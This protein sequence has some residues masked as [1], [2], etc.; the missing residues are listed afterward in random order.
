MVGDV[1]RRFE[2]AAVLQVGGDAG[3][4]EGMVADP[5]LDAAYA[6]C[7]ILPCFQDKTTSSHLYAP[8]VN[9]SFG[10]TQTSRLP[11]QTACRPARAPSA[12]RRQHER[13]GTTNTNL[14]PVIHFH[15]ISDSNL[16]FDPSTMIRS[17]LSRD[18]RT[19]GPVRLTTMV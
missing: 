11:A 6:A 16:P 13:C 17:S 12:F 15:D 4:A 14:A 8:G 2:R 10:M 1:L 18:E 5:G 9:A 19:G 3:G 7:P